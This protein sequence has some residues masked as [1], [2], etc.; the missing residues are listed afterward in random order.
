[1]VL[2]VSPAQGCAWVT[3]A[4]SGI[5]AAVTRRLARE[6]WT[7]VATARRAE[8]L[9]ELAASHAVP[10]RIVVLPGDVTD[11]AAMQAVVARIEQEIGPLALA[12]LNAGTYVRDSAQGL[13]A[14]LVRR[15]F[16]LNVMG[17]VHGLEAALPPMIGRRCGQIAVVAS[18]AGYRGLPGAIAYGASKAALIAMA[19]A[20]KFDLDRLGI[21]I[22]VVTPGFVKTPLTDRNDFPMPFLMP[23]ED[24]AEALVRG[25][26]SRAFEISFPNRFTF[27]LRRL[28]CLPYRLYFP[29]VARV[30]GR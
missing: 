2:T 26:R 9:A 16:E 12:I 29:L 18:A 17:T 23:A 19:E 14:G 22:Q 20:L 6:G 1:M 4:S 30:T 7:V 8:R 21:R 10:G 27:W 15:Q 5:G 3:G 13:D 28:R 11:R 24:A 25:L